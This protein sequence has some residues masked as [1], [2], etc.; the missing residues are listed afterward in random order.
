MQLIFRIMCGSTFK[1]FELLGFCVQ[2]SLTLKR[3]EV[4]P[5]PCVIQTILLSVISLGKIIDSL[6][7]TVIDKMVVFCYHLSKL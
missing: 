3:F 6:K 5:F 2:K 1:N 4:F 7:M